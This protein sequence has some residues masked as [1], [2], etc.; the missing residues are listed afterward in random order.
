MIVIDAWWEW[1]ILVFCTF[2]FVTCLAIS[3]CWTFDTIQ[4]RARRKAKPFND[5]DMSVRSLWTHVS[6]EGPRLRRMITAESECRMTMF[7]ELEGRIATLEQA[8]KR[9]KKRG[10]AK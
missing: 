3:I 4:E 1:A 9:P 10:A 6:G 2:Y 5:L 8:G 7:C